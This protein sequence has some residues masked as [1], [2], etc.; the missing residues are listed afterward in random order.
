[1]GSFHYGERTHINEPFSF[2]VKNDIFLHPLG[3]KKKKSKSLTY[4]DM[5]NVFMVTLQLSFQNIHLGWVCS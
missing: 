1:M 3:C 2:S 4:G 5:T